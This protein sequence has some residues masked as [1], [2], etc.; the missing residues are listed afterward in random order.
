VTLVAIELPG[1]G[2]VAMASPGVDRRDHA[3]LGHPAGDEEDP[4]AFFLEVLDDHS[5]VQAN[6]R[7]DAQRKL[8]AVE[9]GQA[10]VRVFGPLRLWSSDRRD[11]P[12]WPCRSSRAGAWP[13]THSRRR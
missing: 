11:L 12:V 3:V 9:I 4:A 2:L 13:L 6:R 5:G 7:L 8:R 1:L 10:Y